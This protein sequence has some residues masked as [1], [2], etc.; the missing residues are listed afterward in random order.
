MRVNSRY[1]NSTRGILWWSLCT[2]YLSHA[3][4][5]Y[6]LMEFMY[7]AFTRMPGESYCRILRSLLLCLC[8]VFRAQINSHVCWLYTTR[9][10]Y[11]AVYPE[12]SP[13]WAID[14][15]TYTESSWYGFSFD[16]EITTEQSVL[17]GSSPTRIQCNHRLIYVYVCGV[18]IDT[19]KQETTYSSNSDYRTC[20]RKNFR[21]WVCVTADRRREAQQHFQCSSFK[22]RETVIINQTST[23]SISKATLGKLLRDKVERTDTILNWTELNCLW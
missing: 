6:P 9:V 15:I 20:R 23:E 4:W 12:G 16:C 19:D 7:F 3:T 18:F 17:K 21:S 2:L 13:F 14:Y 1:I 22:G 11:L 5:E 8:D 10:S